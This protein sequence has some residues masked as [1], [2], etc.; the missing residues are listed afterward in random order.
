M[1]IASVIG[2]CKCQGYGGGG[3]GGGGGGNGGYG[4]AMGGGARMGANGG[5]G[6]VAGRGGGAF[7]GG[8]G[9]MGSFGMG[10]NGFGGTA[11]MGGAGGGE[12]VQAAIM[13]RQNIEFRDVPSSGMMN[14][15]NI[16]VG[17]SPIPINFVFR[18]VSS[19]LNVQQQHEGA[20]GSTQESS[21]TDEAHR[22][23]HSVTKP[24]I[25]EVRETISPFR[26][27]TQEIQP[28]QEDIQTIVS[29]ES[30]G[31][32]GAGAGG[33]GMAGAFGGGFGAAFGGGFG[34]MRGGAGMGFGTGMRAG[35]AGGYG[36]VMGGGNGGIR[37]AMAGMGGRAAGAKGY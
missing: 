27:I 37:G 8:F 4:G 24:I 3:Y 34:G 36:S 2:L 11:G 7:G 13:S 35:G 18:S 10:L 32:A 25:Q 28:V 26:R 23:V 21:S 12:T 22:L 16:E 29:R 1:L 19:N 5:Y 15:V 9:G 14:P 30:G 20:Q 31:G 17:A 6:G 33:M